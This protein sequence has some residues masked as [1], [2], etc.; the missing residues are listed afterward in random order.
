MWIFGISTW[1]RISQKAKEAIQAHLK[2]PPGYNLLWSG[3]FEYLERARQRL[4]VVV[5]I[6][7][8]LVILLL[9]L[10]TQSLVKVCIILMAIPFSLIGAIWLLYLL[11]YNLS[12]GVFVGI[13]ALAGL[14]AETGAIMLLYLD[15]VYDERK[16][17]GK[18]NTYEDLKEVVMHGAVQRLA[19]QTH[20]DFSQ[21][22][23]PVTGH[24]GHRRRR[25]SGQAHRRPPG[26][27]G[28]HVFPPGIAHLSG[29][30]SAVEVARGGEETGPRFPIIPLSVFGFQFSVKKSSDINK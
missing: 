9:Y 3:Q 30:L 2:L 4:Q 23:R 25:R 13:I 28:D 29:H 7:L 8:V 12:V 6:T 22:F 10:S 24:V 14:D 21:Y 18:L 1:G 20:D 27:R 17:Q 15:I 5:P 26:G 19:P 11:D 16:A